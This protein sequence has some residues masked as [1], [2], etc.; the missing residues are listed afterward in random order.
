MRIDLEA[1]D[2]G[3]VAH[4]VVPDLRE[5]DE[6]SLLAGETVNDRRRTAL[7]RQPVG[8]HGDRKPGIVGD[9]FAERQ[10]AVDVIAGQRAE[11][12]ILRNQAVRLLFETLAILP[13]P[14][15]AQV[16]LAVELAAMIVKGVT[17]LMTDHRADG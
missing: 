9:I 5:T 6:Q 12:V 15:I 1:F 2:A 4:L 16:A 11:G 17:D 14:P 10:R 13:G 8:A 3:G 7:A